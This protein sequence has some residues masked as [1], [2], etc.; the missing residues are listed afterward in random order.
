MCHY[1]LLKQNWYKPEHLHTL[2]FVSFFSDVTLKTQQQM[3]ISSIKD[4]TESALDPEEINQVLHHAK[5]ALELIQYHPEVNETIKTVMLQ[6]HGKKDGIGF[7][8]N[9]GEEIHP[10]AKVFIIS[11]AFIKV[12]LNPYMPSTKKD[13]LTILSSRY[14]A[15]SYQKIIKALEQKFQ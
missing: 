1:V 15:P 12:L 8:E 3:Q 6:S 13:I 7:E 10:L 11:D 5:D 9:P 14:E 2:S 4:L